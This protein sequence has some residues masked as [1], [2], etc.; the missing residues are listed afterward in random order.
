MEADSGIDNMSAHVS[1][2]LCRDGVEVATHFL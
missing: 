1:L 2:H